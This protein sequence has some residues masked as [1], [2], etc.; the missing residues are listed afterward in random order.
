MPCFP[1]PSLPQTENW[2]FATLLG[3]FA[4]LVL[5]MLDHAC[6]ILF[7]FPSLYH[8]ATLHAAFE[9]WYML[10]CALCAFLSLFWLTPDD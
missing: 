9:K 10:G 5:A 3:L 7:G 2:V 4:L 1:L 6:F 8:Y